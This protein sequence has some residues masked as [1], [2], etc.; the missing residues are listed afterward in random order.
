MK[1]FSGFRDHKLRCSLL[2]HALGI[3]RGVVHALNEVKT[4][5]HAIFQIRFYK[6]IFWLIW[7]RWINASIT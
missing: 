3:L 6:N 4:L 1:I 7:F 2:G 5:S